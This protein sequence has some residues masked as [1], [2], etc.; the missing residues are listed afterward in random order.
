MQR[1]EVE[2]IILTAAW[3]AQLGECQSAEWEFVGL[4]PGQTNPQS[5]KITEKKVLPF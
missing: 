2:G 4:N 5:L 3:L 1:Y